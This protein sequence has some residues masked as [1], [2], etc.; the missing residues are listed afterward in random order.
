[1]APLVYCGDAARVATAVLFPGQGRYRCELTATWRHHA[2]WTVVDQAEVWAGR[3]LPELT[4]PSR[5][6]GSVD[7]QLSVV[8]AALTVWSALRSSVEPP[9]VFAGHSL[10]QIT[11][12]IAAGVL[13]F[14]DGLDVVDRRMAACREA[15]AGAMTALVGTSVDQAEATCARLDDAWVANHNSPDQVVVAGGEEATSGVGRDLRARGACSRVVRLPVTAPFH[16]P[17]MADVAAR[18]VRSLTD[19]RFEPIDPPI[20]V[21]ATAEPAPAASSWP[22]ILGDHLESPVRWRESLL[23]LEA[24]GVTRFIEVGGDVLGKFTA[25]TL[26][27]GFHSSSVVVPTDLETVTSARRDQTGRR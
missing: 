13:G 25:C 14:E 19:I 23:T 11:A 8:V 1:M 26:G 12:L 2:A 18:F 7:G 16:T 4:T 22:R 20:V 3:P 24:L 17:A 5:P 10:G 21:N 15:P 9:V 27:D 6:A